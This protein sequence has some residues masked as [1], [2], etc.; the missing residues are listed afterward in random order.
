VDTTWL[1]DR[2]AQKT[3]IT[4]ML[5]ATLENAFTARA[6]DDIFANAAQRQRE[7]ELLFSTVVSLLTL[8]VWRQ[9]NSVSE[10]YK[11]AQDDFEVS[12]RSVYNKL[13]GTETQVCR[14]LVREPAGK[15][16]EVVDELSNRK[17]L[18]KG[19]RTRIIDGNHLTSTDHR[20]KAL[21]RTRS[22]PL[23][24]QTLAVLDADRML[25]T[26]LFCCEDGEAQERR[27]FPEVV[28]AAEPGQLWIADRNF[29]TTQFFFG[30]AQR[31][32]S[33]LIRQ[34][35]STLVWEKET[36]QQRV[37]RSDSGVIY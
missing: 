5:R 26:D 20:L 15:L 16:V 36:R 4:V 17:P 37:G 23:P 31:G 33:F 29:C 19:Y 30:L 27:L 8:V 10:A 32:A 13:N 24:G 7:G 6:L 9:K 12:L 2:F 22:G 14:A 28:P 18:L 21:R 35:A 11:H 25:I 1:F 3:P 34:H